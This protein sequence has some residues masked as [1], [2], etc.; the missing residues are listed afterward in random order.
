MIAPISRRSVVA[1]ITVSLIASRGARADDPPIIITGD[2]GM[3]GTALKAHWASRN[4]VGVD[5]KRGDDQDLMLWRWENLVQ[6]G[7]TV[8][9]LAIRRGWD[10]VTA[11][12][13]H[14]LNNHVLETC[15]FKKVRRLIFTSSQMVRAA[16]LHMGALTYY[17][18][19]KLGMEAMI[20]AASEQGSFQSRIL[21][22]GSFG[23]YKADH[24]WTRADEATLGYWFDLAADMNDV[25]PLQTW[26][27]IGRTAK[28]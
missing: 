25:S 12:Y 17:A 22:L 14:R 3:V 28:D 2:M 10:F 21:R 13:D 18:A 11:E 4:I 23:P 15:I 1:G 5:I 8:V 16:D 7:C 26:D 9:H 27:V 6:P 19:E 24:D 20:R